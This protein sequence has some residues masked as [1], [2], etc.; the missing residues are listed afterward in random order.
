MPQYAPAAPVVE[1]IMPQQQV[2]YTPAPMGAVAAGDT[3][4]PEK[5]A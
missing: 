1:T 4:P 2:S 5:G 3:G